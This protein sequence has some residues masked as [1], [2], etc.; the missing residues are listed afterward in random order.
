MASFFDC[1]KCFFRFLVHFDWIIWM[2]CEI[3]EKFG[4][5]FCDIST[6]L[7]L[8]VFFAHLQVQ[9]LSNFRVVFESFLTN[10]GTI[11][12]Q[13]KVHFFGVLHLNLLF[14][15]LLALFSSISISLINLS[16]FYPN[17]LPP[18]KKNFKKY[19]YLDV[20]TEP[21]CDEQQVAQTQKRTF[22]SLLILH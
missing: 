20:N 9:S 1:L 13:R 4:G 6:Q 5:L 15:L 19:A 16:Y 18:L 12:P 11:F 14:L 8:K 21:Y 22:C 17:F 3:F 10:S 7:I 2:N